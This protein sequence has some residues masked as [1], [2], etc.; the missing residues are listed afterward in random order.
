MKMSITW[1]GDLNVVHDLRSSNNQAN[2]KIMNSVSFDK[3]RSDNNNKIRHAKNIDRKRGNN[4]TML[5]SNR[6]KNI[7]IT[8]SCDLWASKTLWL[9]QC[10]HRTQYN[11]QAA[12]ECSTRRRKKNRIKRLWRQCRR[13]CRALLRYVTI[14]LHFDDHE[15]IIF[16]LLSMRWFLLSFSLPPSLSISF[17]R[18]EYNNKTEFRTN[19]PKKR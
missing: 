5:I 1:S 19:R 8:F 9:Y 17:F 6:S 12:N 4:C 16:N 11:S 13:R 7:D 15:T 2:D 14:I 3:E 10:Y 18:Y